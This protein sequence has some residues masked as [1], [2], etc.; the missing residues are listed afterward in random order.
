[1]G[2]REIIEEYTGNITDGNFDAPDCECENCRKKPD[3]FKLHESR[4]RQLRFLIGDVVEIAATFLLRWKCLLCGGTF[5]QYPPFV[6]PHKRFVVPDIVRLGRK[7]L[8]DENASYADAVTEDGNQIGYTNDCGFCDSFV[9]RSTVWRF[10][11][12]LGAIRFEKTEPSDENRQRPP[13]L[14]PWKYRSE[15][16]NRLLRRAFEAVAQLAPNHFF[17]SFP[18][19]ET[20]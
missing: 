2:I 18:D 3:A 7:Y 4:K 8:E 9:S 14:P 16:R 17:K 1:M 12:Y 6:A 10:M 20:A 13:C 15:K 19:L 11:E 5:T